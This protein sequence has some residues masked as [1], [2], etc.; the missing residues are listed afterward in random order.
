MGILPSSRSPDK[1]MDVSETKD[2][3]ARDKSWGVPTKPSAAQCAES[4]DWMERWARLQQHAEQSP[5]QA[6]I[7]KGACCG[8]T[9]S[10]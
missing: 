4:L 10:P 9:S 8:E 6:W 1:S 5:E 7:N 2:T 3:N